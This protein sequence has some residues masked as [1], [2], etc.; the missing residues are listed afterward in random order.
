MYVNKDKQRFIDSLEYWLRLTLVNIERTQEEW[1]I[2]SP[3]NNTR[4]MYND[5]NKLK[6]KL[7]IDLKYYHDWLKEI[8]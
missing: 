5:I 3:E 2:Y 1:N 8:F 6:S 4:I 7:K